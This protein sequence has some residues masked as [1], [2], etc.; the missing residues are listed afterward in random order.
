MTALKF[1]NPMCSFPKITP[2][3]LALFQRKRC[4]L[5]DLSFPQC[6]R[7]PGNVKLAPSP[8]TISIHWQPLRQYSWSLSR[9]RQYAWSEPRLAR[10]VAVCTPPFPIAHGSP[11]RGCHGSKT[12]RNSPAAH[13]HSHLIPRLSWS[14]PSSL[15]DPLNLLSS[16]STW[17]E[18]SVVCHPDLYRS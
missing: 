1:K 13:N 7:P 16:C 15:A 5:C 14:P 17:T 9:C 10:G 2:I 8:I 3:F 18:E 11:R 4:S 12:T 6:W